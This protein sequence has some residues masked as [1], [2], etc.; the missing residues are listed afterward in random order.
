MPFLVGSLTRE[1]K[2]RGVNLGGWLLF[3]PGPSGSLSS[4]T[5]ARHVCEWDFMMGLRAE[6]KLDK[7]TEHRETYI[8][9]DDFIKIKS[10]GLNA[11]RLPF[12]YWV[13][14][15]C[16]H[17]EPYSGP[18]L[19][20][21]DRAVSWAE[22]HGLQVLL[23]LHGNPG[24]ESGGAPCGR[25][26]PNWHWTQWRQEQSLEAL[27]V[28]SE[29]Y[30]NRRAVTGI[31]VCNEP[32]KTIPVEALCSYYQ[33][34]VRM[35]RQNGLPA[36]KATV[37][38]PA[39]QRPLEE[40]TQIWRAMTDTGLHDNVCL[41]FHYYHCFGDFWNGITFEEHLREVKKRED[42]LGQFPAIVGE[43]SLALGKAAH[44]GVQ[45]SHSEMRAKFGSTQL[46]TYKESSHGYFFWNWS[47]AHG[48]EWDFQSSFNES[49]LRIHDAR[50]LSGTPLRR[51]RTLSVALSETPETPEKRPRSMTSSIVV[52]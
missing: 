50:G 18:A 25:R 15:G 14:L 46:A 40:V 5:N 45:Q 7:L 17:G 20:Y 33:G 6:G 21:I 26:Q 10:C 37:V 44:C 41:D 36:S 47:D 29:R 31:Q 4:V 30:C 48:T 8:T 38:L 49:S 2:W 13:V 27:R 28:L 39:F 1:D 35:I 34:A 24:G 42:E 19:E 32:S 12:G 9:E 23:D 3:E 16:S 22:K 43:W 51:K 52:K 11:V